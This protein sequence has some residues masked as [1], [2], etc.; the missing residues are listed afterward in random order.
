MAL[1]C[2]EQIN[3]AFNPAVSGVVLLL[4]TKRLIDHTSLA[5]FLGD[6]QAKRLKAGQ[7]LRLPSGAM[8]R[9]ETRRTVSHGF[10]RNTTVIGFYAATL[11]WSRWTAFGTWLA[12]SL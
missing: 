11:S 10:S 7:Q 4:H 3:G 9:V 5:G 8:L 1:V 12:L 2:A 6:A